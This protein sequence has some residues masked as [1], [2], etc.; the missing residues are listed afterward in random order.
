MRKTKDVE[1]FG[2]KV[3]LSERSAGDRFSLAEMAAIEGA[4][5][6]ERLPEMKLGDLSMTNEEKI[7]VLTKHKMA[8]LSRAQAELKYYIYSLAIRQSLGYWIREQFILFRWYWKLKFTAKKLLKLTI[9]KLDEYNKV[10]AELEDETD[11]KKV[12]PVKASEEALQDA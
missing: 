6:I 1:I 9:R 8:N 7:E 12:E 2:K 10:L 3:K 11:K 4:G 5:L